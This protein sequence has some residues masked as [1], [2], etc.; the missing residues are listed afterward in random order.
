MKTTRTFASFCLTSSCIALVWAANASVG[1]QPG[2]FQMTAAPHETP[3][4]VQNIGTTSLPNPNQTGSDSGE[5]AGQVKL[6]GGTSPS[7]TDPGQFLQRSAGVTEPILGRQAFQTAPS[8]GPH[9]MFDQ[10]I[11]DSLGMQDSYTRINAFI[12]NQL[13]PDTTILAM[14][15]SASLTDE[16][17]DLYNYGAVFRHYDENRNRIWG[18]NVFGDHDNTGRLADFSRVGFGIENLGRYVDFIVNGYLTTGEDSRL[19]SRTPITGLALSGNNVVRSFSEIRENAYQGLDWKVGTPLPWLGRRGVKMFLGSYWLTNSVSEEEA[20]GVSAQW[21][22]QATD[23]L[24]VNAYYTNDGCFGSN[25]WV[26]VAFTIPH[27]GQ[28]SILRPK[29]VRRR[30][31]DPVRRTNTIHKKHESS[32]IT[33]AEINA[34]TGLPWFI[35]YVDPNRDIYEPGIGTVEDPFAELQIA[36][37]GNAATVDAI[38]ITPRADG[39]GT[40]LTVDGGLALFAEQAVFS[41]HKDFALFSDDGME[42]V[43]PAASTSTAGP[44]ITNP[45]IDPTD[46]ANNAVIR[47]ADWNRIK[48]LQIDGANADDTA[49]GMG[50]DAPAAFDGIHLTSN[51]FTN[52]TIGA[53]LPGTSG[54]LIIDENT[55]T[56]LS[57]VSTHGLMLS[58]T[59]GSTS[60]LRVRDNTATNNSSAGLYVRAAA[61]STINAANPLGFGALP[62]DPTLPPGPTMFGPGA[63]TATGITDNITTNNGDGLSLNADAGATFNAVIERNTSSSNT[64]NGL[65]ARVDGAGAAFNIFSMRDNTLAMNTGNGAFLNY[66][67]GADFRSVT[68]DLNSNGIL[69]LSEDTNGNGV[70]DPSEDT[71]GNGILDPGEDLNGNEILDPA[72]DLDGDGILDPT[73]DTNGNGM[74][75]QGIVSNIFS[76]NTIA[77]LCIFG[78]GDPTI[79]NSGTGG[80]GIFDIGGPQ[81]SLG[82][83]FLSNQGA[84]IGVD[85]FDS[86]TYQADTVN[87]V[88]RP[89]TGGVPGGPPSLTF[90]LDFWEASQGTLTDAFGNDIVPFDV[91]GFGF[92]ATD[93]D[94][95][96]SAVLDQVRDHYY[97]IPTIGADTRSPIP[98]GQQLS[99]DFVLGDIGTAPSNG[100]TD[101]YYTVIGGSTSPGTP[102]G[103]G[104]LSAARNAAGG[105]PNFGFGSGD[106]LSSVYSDNINGLGGLTPADI[107]SDHIADLGV[108][109]DN[110]ALTDA[111]TS[112]NLTFTRNALAGTVS[113]EIGHNLSLTHMNLAGAVTPTGA[114]PI[115]GTGAI[116]TP[117]QARIGP[118]EFSYSGQNAQAGNATQTHVSQLMGA[119]GTRAAIGSGTSGAGI[120]LVGNDSAVVEPSTWLNN[121]IENNGG[122][123]LSIQM[124]DSARANDVTIQ[125]NT[126][127]NNNGRGINLEAHGAAAFIEASSTIGGSGMNSVGGTLFAQGNTITGNQS[128]G[129][130]AFATQGATIL[131]NA[132]DNTITQNAGNGI[133]LLIEEGGTIDFATAAS[134]R[135]I[136]G[137]TIT[138]NA[139]AGILANSTVDETVSNADQEMSLLVQGNTI[140]S[141]VTGGVVA[142]L[143]GPNNTPPGPP[144]LGFDENNVL[145][146]TIGQTTS[147]FSTPVATQSNVFHQNGEVGI[148]LTVNGNGLANVSIVQNTITNTTSGSNALFNGDGINV[149]RRD[150]SLVLADIFHNSVT[151]SASNGLEV[152]TQGTN[153]SNVNQPMSGMANSVTWNN[154][155]LDNNGENGA[156]FR[157][158]GDSQLIADG[159]NNF[160]RGNAAQ[161]IDIETTENSSFGDPSV[162]VPGALGRRVVFDGNTS[163]GNGVDGLWATAS[164][165]SYLLLEVTSTR[166]PT[167]SGAHGSLNTNGDSNYSGNGF[168]GIHLDALGSSVVDL[169]VTADTGYTF[170]Q[171]NGTSGVG[172]GGVYINAGDAATGQV[173]ITRSVITGT[174]AGSTEDT[175]GNGV[176]DGGEDLNGNE[177]IDVTGGDAISY[178]A[179][180]LSVVDLVVG[181]TADTGNIIQN[182]GD[183]GIAVTTDGSV[184]PTIDISFNVIGGA[185]NGIAAGNTGD[186]ISI[187]GTGQTAEGVA[188]EEFDEFSSPWGLAD[189]F[190]LDGPAPNINISNNMITR[191]N[192]T[193]VNV[194]LNGANGLTSLRPSPVAANLNLINRIT[195]TDN[196][197]SSNGEHG[198]VLRADADMHQNRS[199]FIANLEQ[200]PL[201]EDLNGNGVLDLNLNED[202]NMN[203]VLDLSEDLNGNGILELNLSEDVNMN[204]EL[205]AGSGIFDNT[206]FSFANVIANSVFLA[207]DLDILH[208]YNNLNTVQNTVFTVTGNTI[209]N[210][211]TNTVVGRG[212]EVQVGTSAYV[213]L[214]A[215]DNTFGGNLEADFVSGA[216]LSDGETFASFDTDGEGTFDVIYLDDAAILD[217]RF[218][219]NSGDQLIP[220][221]EA[222]YL[223]GDPL[224]DGDS[225]ASVFKIDNF[226]ALDATNDFVELGVTQSITGAFG[227]YDILNLSEEFIWPEDPFAD[228][229]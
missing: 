177:D 55:F 228:A 142:E 208:P 63:V 56:G 38:R 210:N 53:N 218:T 104:F 18:V 28:H 50:I 186:G 140:S 226:F 20:L 219:G 156:V 149:I 203:G 176:L 194:R 115:M 221:A 128:D 138:G 202:L 25:S 93:F 51:T 11:D 73:E 169:R 229:D 57:G 139:G 103:V 183:D 184:T 185:H 145:N 141:N 100:A 168:D 114:P 173:S 207:A 40:H 132:I 225:D 191:N 153:R 182:N 181:G 91:T 214:D 206:D 64:V 174:V 131:G 118:R 143:N 172:N 59:A 43:I 211:G 129:V 72:E 23:S 102:L 1:D 77:G 175:N 188:P 101:F 171:D 99:I 136:S 227:D 110:V 217:V 16:G 111:L 158:R 30:L 86:A 66:R 159:S 197:I 54:E 95:V 79:D 90:V 89:G 163:T 9:L 220:G 123:A 121:T 33:A 44:L 155:I 164:E 96:T 137:N 167:V 41:S 212:L 87:N 26:N 122:D 215:R 78:E 146:L 133:A 124:N 120:V 144:A 195:L 36:A 31:S 148:G 223:T 224:K 35:N 82:N 5:P 32:I 29:T 58:T 116:D 76:D 107:G 70:L 162:F 17:N 19:S 109:G 88:I 84:G 80:S 74:L 119:L 42:F 61:G 187:V 13:V 97:D 166:V 7:F 69:D 24:E 113:H 213:A 21:Q 193:G 189:R 83:Q 112:G 98:D 12:P 92:A 178:N 216:F 179:S 85:L 4:V 126:I 67:N 15:L 94:M 65:L 147:P 117:N 47:V 39:S 198:V 151:G 200:P 75:D 105:G 157:T 8:L 209:Q 130:R 10:T 49:W 22:I 37:D 192:R 60:E 170:I 180:G 45:T 108:A 135:I 71:N 62:P 165:G 27:K 204:G 34:A 222:S 134:N 6:N 199:V 106:Q 81:G 160:L 154:N 46:P 52:Y 2:V 14:S 205:D 201:D 125:T 161:G 127:R 3:G 68:E 196:T 48:G 152:D 190:L 150:S